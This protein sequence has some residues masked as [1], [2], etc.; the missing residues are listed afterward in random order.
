MRFIPDDGE[1]VGLFDTFRT[2]GVLEVMTVLDE[3]EDG[4][5]NDGFARTIGVGVG[6]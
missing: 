5:C 3:T 6:I 4:I 2:S 1:A